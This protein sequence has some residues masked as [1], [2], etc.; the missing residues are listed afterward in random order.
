[1]MIFEELAGLFVTH[2][3]LDCMIHLTLSPVMGLYV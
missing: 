1:M 3:R 2:G